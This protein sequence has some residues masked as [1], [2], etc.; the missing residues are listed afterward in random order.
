MSTGDVVTSLSPSTSPLLAISLT[1]E[2]VQ[3]VPT[4]LTTGYFLASPILLT[5]LSPA[6]ILLLQVPWGLQYHPS[7]VF[8]HISL[9]NWF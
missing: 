4:L 7:V 6:W 3:G 8:N 1:M 9:L 2:C 5:A